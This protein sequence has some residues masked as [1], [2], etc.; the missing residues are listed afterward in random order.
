MLRT[1]YPKLLG[2]ISKASGSGSGQSK[3]NNE[4]P[5]QPRQ[6]CSHLVFFQRLLREI[7]LS[8][9][10]QKKMNCHSDHFLKE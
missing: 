7:Q 5:T 2:D 6:H 8:E 10:I 4:D 3:A 1:P 9:I